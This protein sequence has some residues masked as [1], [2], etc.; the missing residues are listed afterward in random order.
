[1]RGY[2]GNF[3]DGIFGFG[4]FHYGGYIMMGIGLV[5]ILV[6]AYLAVRKG[7]ILPSSGSQSHE[8]PME[9]LQKRY[10]NGDIS[11]EEFIEKQE[12]LKQK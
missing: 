9:I 8:T 3:C 5:I 6:L 12:I 11:K 10:V 1:M 2:Y 4:R 7:N